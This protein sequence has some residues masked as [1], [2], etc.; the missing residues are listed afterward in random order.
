[1]KKANPYVVQ[2]YKNYF[3]R[4]EKSLS[5]DSMLGEVRKQEIQTLFDVIYE[6]PEIPKEELELLKPK[7][8]ATLTSIVQFAKIVEKHFALTVNI[9]TF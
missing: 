2:F 1:M 4:N 8:L 5:S 9:R 3:K 7:T 6:I